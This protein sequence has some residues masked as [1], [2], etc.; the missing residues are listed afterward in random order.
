MLHEVEE[1]QD[2]SYVIN[3]AWLWVAVYLNIH[4]GDAVII[5]NAIS[6]QLAQ[7]TSTGQV[8][9]IL[10]TLDPVFVS[11]TIDF[12]VNSV[13]IKF[14]STTHSPTTSSPTSTVAPTSSPLGTVLSFEGIL[15]I[16]LVGAFFIIG[17]FLCFIHNRKSSHKYK[18]SPVADAADVGMSHADI[19][20]K[21]VSSSPVR[22]KPK[23]RKALE[24][25]PVEVA[26]APKTSA[27][28]DEKK[29]GQALQ[30]RF[31]FD[32]GASNRRVL[33]DPDEADYS[34]LPSPTHQPDVVIKFAER[35]PSGGS[36]RHAHSVAGV[37]DPIAHPIK[38]NED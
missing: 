37:S 35:R 8:T 29:S 4:S 14:D 3:L 21:P 13:D 24:D 22:S 2:V 10:A 33:V 26:P 7:A 6:E 32:T 17:V 18:V 23:P 11:A 5:E 27:A 9:D 36:G 30:Q 38:R 28:D 25:D 20:E 1:L 15:S 12:V 31:L 34:E 16:S 19:A